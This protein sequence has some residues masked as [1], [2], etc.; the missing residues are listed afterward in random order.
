[1]LGNWLGYTSTSTNLTVNKTSK[2]VQSTKF[3]A[4]PPPHT[5]TR[6]F[7]PSPTPTPPSYYYINK[8]FNPKL[9]LLLI[10]FSRTLDMFFSN[11]CL[12]Y[13][14]KVRVAIS[15]YDPALSVHNQVRTRLYSI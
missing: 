5:R 12:K 4:L 14:F 9:R 11:P 7:A 6:M 1:M 15:T 8:H 2:K 10:K 3:S 13:F